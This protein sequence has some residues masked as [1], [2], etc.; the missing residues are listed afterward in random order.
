MK[1]QKNICSD[2]KLG[3]NFSEENYSLNFLITLL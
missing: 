3:V 2:I 1:I